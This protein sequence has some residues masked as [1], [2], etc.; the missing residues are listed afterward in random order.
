MTSHSRGYIKPVEEH[1]ADCLAAVSVLPTLG[2]APLDA[3]D[4][5]LAE[6]IV[7]DVDLPSFDNSSMDGY[8]V[9]MPDVAAAT[10][11]R[12]VSLPVVGDIAAGSRDHLRLSPGSAL[13]IMTGAPMPAGADAVVPVE[14][15]DGGV[16]RV[17]IQRAPAAGQYVRSVG[18]DVRKGE[19]LL[20]E[21]I[22][23]SP[24]Q[25]SLLSAIGRSRVRVR[26]RPRVVVL[27]SGSE[28]ME[29]GRPLGYGQIYDSNG[30]GLA[31]A[32]AELGAVARHVGIVADE[33]R[34]FS[35]MLEDQLV[36]ADL[37]IT[38]GGVSMGAYDIVKEVLSQLGT[39]TFD[40]VAMQ[41]G[42]P[43][44]FGTIGPDATP[45]FTLPGNPVSAMVSFEVFVRP[46]IRKMFGEANLH[47]H[48]LVAEAT[49]GWFSPEGKRQF[50]RARL[51]RRADGT[52]V[53]TPVGGQG[54]HLVADLAEATCLAV[55]P[56]PV[57]EVRPGDVLRCLLLD[58][59]RR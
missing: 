59:T 51:Q 16:A 26:P 24:R 18:E 22:R 19:V 2:L 29:P 44:G 41:P 17:Q 1:L 27:S 55:V 37:L 11:S 23:L 6:D 49:Q 36:R 53:V 56:E 33:P 45:I 39:V 12:P 4:C 57:T 21:G 9:T 48:S 25:V 52:A 40:K 47:R 32:A 13:R 28:L 10:P 20:R 7:A 38:S 8:A 58:R 34:E 50:V 5:V 42:M 15:T 43:Q 46:V 30:Y 54:S 35:A 31:A 14:W 3:L